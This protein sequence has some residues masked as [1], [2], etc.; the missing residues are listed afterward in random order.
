MHKDTWT[1]ERVLKMYPVLLSLV[2]IPRVVAPPLCHPHAWGKVCSSPRL[3]INSGKEVVEPEGGVGS[4]G[5][6]AIAPFS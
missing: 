4:H 5:F 1:K 6:A 3:C 2:I